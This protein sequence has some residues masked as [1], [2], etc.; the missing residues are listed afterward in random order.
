MNPLKQ[1]HDD[2]HTR[3]A[4]KEYLMEY[5]DSQALEKVKKFEDIKGIAESYEI[6]RKAFKNL[7]DEY[8]ETPEPVISS[9]R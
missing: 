9:S 4:V 6:I 2:K 3:E 5:L 7:E 1:F 8:G